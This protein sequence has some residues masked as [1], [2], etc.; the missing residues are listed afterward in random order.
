MHRALPIV[1]G[2]VCLSCGTTDTGGD[3][4]PGMLEY[5]PAGAGYRIR[6]AN[7]P[8]VEAAA[9]TT[10]GSYRPNL[11]V[12]LA[13]LGVSLDIYSY[14]LQ[15]DP[16]DGRA[17]DVIQSLRQAALA[18][19][20][21]VDFEVRAILSNLG[22]VG[23]EFGAHGGQLAAGLPESAQ[24]KIADHG[25]T[26]HLRQAVFD[27]PRGGC[28]AVLVLSIYDLEESELTAMLR[29]FHVDAVLQDGGAG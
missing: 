8:W 12:E 25:Y 7:P 4:A 11:L 17:A 1:I 14:V 13:L 23:F 6:Y 2:V 15:I 28:F 18:A 19:D 21:I 29:S 20:E 27:S 24:K 10:Y 5:A 3:R 26:V 9:G 16:L 22:D